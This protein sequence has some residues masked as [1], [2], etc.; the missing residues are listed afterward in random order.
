MDRLSWLT[1]YHRIHAVSGIKRLMKNWIKT[2]SDAI[3]AMWKTHTMKYSDVL[4]LPTDSNTGET[5]IENRHGFR[6]NEWWKPVLCTGVKTVRP[7]IEK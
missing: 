3:W 4:E 5:A 2:V 6:Y 7:E 1:R